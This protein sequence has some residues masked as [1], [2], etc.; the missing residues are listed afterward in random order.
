MEFD[1]RNTK[2]AEPLVTVADETAPDAPEHV[3]S[4]TSFKRERAVDEVPEEPQVM[5]DTEK[6]QLTVTG[7]RRRIAEI[8][9]IARKYEIWHDLTPVRLRRMLEE[10]G[11]MF[12]KT[13]RF[14]PTRS[15]VPAPALLR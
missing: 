8:F 5:A 13:G 1:E 11:A 2:S 9:H 14:S 4:R 10:L 6:Y 15:D 7:R 12:A 3:P